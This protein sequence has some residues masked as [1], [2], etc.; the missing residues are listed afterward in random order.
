MA[1]R[2]AAGNQFLSFTE[3]VDNTTAIGSSELQ[4]TLSVAY[5]TDLVAEDLAKKR[6]GYDDVS[7]WSTYNIR[8]GLEYKNVNGNTQNL[9]YGESSTISGT[10][11]IL[12]TFSGTST[13]STLRS[14]LRDGIKPSIF[15][16]RS[17]AYLLNGADN[18]IFDGTSVRQIGID[19]P[20]GAPSFVTNIAGS[21]VV[22]GS[23]LFAYS[24]YNSQTGAES[25][26]SPVSSS[27]VSG[28]TA[29]LA[30]F[31]ISI[32]AGNSSLA[33]KIRI[34]RSVSG[35][36]VL[37]LEDEIAISST[38][39]DSTA[40]DSAL[41]TEA[42]LDNSRLPEPATFGLV[43]DNR[44]F[45]GG[46]PSN[47]N[48]LQYSKVG[49]SGPMPES[50]QALDFLDCNINDGDKI[51]GLGKASGNVIVIKD[52]SVGRLVQV[53]SDT[54]GLERQGS[55][56]Y[57]YEEISSEV[58][59]ISHH[60]IVS[61]DNI[62]IWFGKDDIYGTDG[63][64]IFRFGKRVRNTIKNLDFNHSNKWSSLVKT[65]SQQI[66]FSVTK[67][68]KLEAD[69][70]FVGHYRNFPKIAFT[71][72]TAGPV[73]TTHPGLV[74]GCFFAATI[75]GITKFFFGS[76]QA[77]G[78]IYQ[79]DVGDNDDT[80][81][82]YWD[83]RLPWDGGRQ[84]MA[85]KHFHSYYLF[86]AG[87]GITPDNVIT[88]TFEENTNEII[89][90]T[91]TSTLV[92]TNPVWNTPNWGSFNWASVTFNPLKF[93]PNKKAYYGRYGWNNTYANQPV[94]VRAL[95]GVWQPVALH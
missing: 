43:N 85:K 89:T 11:G 20:T 5:N 79:M 84:T 62:V 74:V 75:N 63:S 44:V 49:I 80:Y 82:I 25:N 46:F 14:G 30:G 92:G 45:V 31:T 65:D 88:H 29:S 61:L 69:F 13:P 18:L 57:I 52:R 32:V 38:S 10:S 16:Y 68:D 72:Y 95:A 94:A 48:R 39:Y 73:T 41:G 64:Q 6:A 8:G 33:D 60:L 56:K 50:F 70:Q 86:A 55:V 81:G 2:D 42:E 28:S 76:A 37:F 71:F 78:K 26:I 67:Q 34:Y 23:Y 36:S 12:G 40:L 9:V 1:I 4:G 47:P 21:Q 27:F 54:G 58:T 22:S 90:K 35:G 91:A 93:F 77:S 19:G 15:Q 17:L 59:G 7:T 83:M 24:Y 66:I 51:V 3:G 87:A 53:A